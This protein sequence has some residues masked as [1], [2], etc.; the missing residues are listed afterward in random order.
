M[1]T[2]SMLVSKGLRH[3]PP[4]TPCSCRAVCLLWRHRREGGTRQWGPLRPRSRL[5]TERCSEEP[6]TRG[7]RGGANR[8][9]EQTGEAF[10]R[11]CPPC[12]Q[13]LE[14]RNLQRNQ[15][16]RERPLPQPGLPWPCSGP[17]MPGR[18]GGAPR[19]AGVWRARGGGAGLLTRL[20]SRGR[21]RARQAPPLGKA[22]PLSPPLRDRSA[23]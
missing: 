1:C 7:A 5:R 6:R 17:S 18:C 19:G 13:G 23:A 2:L 15:G 14:D 16:G 12:Q 22:D 21:P 10:R 9:S 20:G 4:R 8:P 11:R 3:G